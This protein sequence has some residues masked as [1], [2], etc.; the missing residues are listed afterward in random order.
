MALRVVRLGTPRAAGEGLRIG[1]VRRLPRGVRKEDYGRRDFFDVWLPE[2]GPSEQL[3]SWARVEP[4]LGKRWE[5]F[6]REYL[7]EM[8]DPAKQH[9]I[10]LLAALSRDS[11]LSVG[12]YCEDAEHCH[13]ALLRKLLEDAGAVMT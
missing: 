1:T 8:K 7:R 6:G 11:E 9:L 12:C 10:R 3:L 5:R 13:R 4:L 2:L